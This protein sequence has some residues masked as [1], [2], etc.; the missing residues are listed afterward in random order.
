M[1]GNIQ[2]RKK[3]FLNRILFVLIALY[4][5]SCT[6]SFI[7]FNFVRLIQSVMI[8]LF[9]V[10]IFV[11]I[12][13]SKDTEKIGVYLICYSIMI[14]LYRL[15]NISTASW[16]N[17]LFQILFFIVIV[18]SILCLEKMPVKWNIYLYFIVLALIATT[19]YKDIIIGQSVA[20]E[21]L[22][23]LREE[24][25]RAQRTAFSTM[26]LFVFCTCWLVFF[27]TNNRFIRWFHFAFALLSLYY[28]VFVGMRASVVIWTLMAFSLIVFE[29]YSNKSKIGRYL[30]VFI[31]VLLCFILIFDIT[32]ILQLLVR[33]SPSDRL[34]VRFESLIYTFNNGIEEDSFSGRM[35]LETISLQSWT[36]SFGS[37]LFGIGDHRLEGYGYQGFIMSGVG[38]HSELIDSLARYGI[39]GFSIIALLIYNIFQYIQNLFSER[40]LRKQVSTILIIAIFTMLTKAMFL[41][42]IGL[43]LFFLLPLS[44]E[45][46]NHFSNTKQ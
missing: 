25:S 33:L 5:A 11:C 22:L 40:A 26:M 3:S 35:K 29:K 15:L 18:A 39:I 42:E 34:S 44:S 16:G 12:I 6:T 21:N 38:G 27:N 46:I 9:F 10:V 1:V 19:V 13:Q 2:T 43:A 20:S 23:L 31:I 32:P 36:S 30:G 7:P 28:I 45:I 24:G 14:F 8:V 37:F 41:P 4:S 17:Y